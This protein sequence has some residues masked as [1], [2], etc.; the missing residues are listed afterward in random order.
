MNKIKKMMSLILV[1]AFMFSLSANAFV[2]ADN[3]ESVIYNCVSDTGTQIRITELKNSDGSFTYSEYWDEKLQESHTTVPGSGF[4]TSETYKNGKKVSIKTEK[5]SDNFS[6]SNYATTGR[7]DRTLGYMNYNNGIIAPISILC[8][9]EEYYSPNNSYVVN[10][11]IAMG[12]SEWIT[13]FVGA[14]GFAGGVATGV[15]TTM[16]ADKLLSGVINN[17]VTSLVTTNVTANVYDQT[18]V[19]NCTTHSKPERRL[20]KGQI[21]YVNTGSGLKIYKDGYNTTM[22]GT[23]ELGRQMFWRVWG[24]EYTPTSWTGL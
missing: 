8:Y 23:G 11:N 13:R 19:G 17:L 12:L 1:I 7:Q 18:I 20:P 16:M 2:V 14:L 3:K 22:W 24:T 6:T 9:V 10:A 15:V 5:I 4:V 21:A